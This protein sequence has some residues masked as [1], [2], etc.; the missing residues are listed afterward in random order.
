[1]EWGIFLR[2]NPIFMKSILTACLVFI[3]I[4][5][6]SAQE[7]GWA[8]S[9]S[10]GGTNTFT[11]FTID[12]NGNPLIA[13]G[14]EDYGSGP[15]GFVIQ[16]KASGDG[17]NMFTKKY[18]GNNGSRCVKMLVDQD[19]N[20]YYVGYFY[21]N[22]AFGTDTLFTASKA[23]WNRTDLMVAKFDENGNYLWSRNM[24]TA[25]MEEKDV[26]IVD[27]HLV[28]NRLVLMA[29]FAPDSLFY[30]NS[31]VA[32]T[33]F[34]QQFRNTYYVVKI[35]ADGSLHSADKAGVFYEDAVKSFR[36][37]T[38][39]TYNITLNRDPYFVNATISADGSAITATDSLAWRHGSSFD[40]IDGAAE[41]NYYYMLIS[42]SGTGPT[43][44][45][46]GTADTI[47]NLP[48]TYN[49]RHAYL[50][51]FDQN[52]D[53][54]KGMALQ[55][56]EDYPTL[57]FSKG[58]LVVQTRFSNTLYFNS[59]DDSIVCANNQ[60]AH[61]LIVLDNNF[62]VQD[63]FQVNTANSSG[64]SFS[65]KGAHFDNN[66]NLYSQ[67][68]HNKNI[69]FGSEVVQAALKSW[70][71]LTVMCKRNGTGGEP[72]GLNDEPA[73]EEI[74][75]YPNPAVDVI[76]VSAGVKRARVVDV[77][78]RELLSAE[79]SSIEVSDLKAG[80]YFLY[81]ET[82]GGVCVRKFLKR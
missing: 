67:Y 47:Y 28:D 14:S 3:T 45:P 32:K 36:V 10:S 30:N 74:F 9:V 35:N 77:T 63:R 82:E 31:F 71:H 25:M 29:W 64:G 66:G 60:H 79:G 55:W 46:V 40:F 62:T 24:G 72:T 41:G 4:A 70:D 27:A 52:F 59:A 23:F 11:A 69:L 19:N 81:M 48:G 56:T 12:N 68:V 39:G 58:K 80:T 2:L 17:A 54:D 73:G 57:N 7:N 16:K 20:M 51:R 76:M 43:G 50:V 53:Y 6:V 13:G 49:L 15:N 5:S 22:I 61:A 34:V 75:A 44:F 78:G 1:M 26:N 21:G 18:N 8:K 33:A 42:S 37:N 65:F 38:D